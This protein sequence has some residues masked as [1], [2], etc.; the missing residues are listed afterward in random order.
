MINDLF[1]S[2]AIVVVVL[3]V[4]GLVWGVIE[5]GRDKHD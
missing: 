2:L 3:V 1:I 4:G 5:L